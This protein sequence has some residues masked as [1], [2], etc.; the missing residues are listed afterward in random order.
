MYK[1]LILLLLASYVL[2]EREITESC[3]AASSMS[4]GE[5]NKVS[6]RS[7]PSTPT[8]DFADDL[9]SRV[10]AA[11]DFGHS[12]H[13]IPSGVYYPSSDAQISEIVKQTIRDNGQ[14]SVRG[15]GHGTNGQMQCCGCT[16]IDMR[17]MNQI[18]NVTE[19]SIYIEAGASLGVAYSALSALGKALV[20]QT[21]WPRLSVGGVMSGSGG[22]GPGLFRH[23]YLSDSILE[24][25][26]VD[27]KGEI[28]V[29]SPT[30][31]GELFNAVVSSLGQFG[32]MTAVKFRAVDIPG[33]KIR[34]YHIYQTLDRVFET[35]EKVLD[36][37]SNG[38]AP[39]HQFKYFPVL[40]QAGSG[41]P[42]G[43]PADFTVSDFGVTD[44]FV[45]ILEWG[46]Y[47][48]I[49]DEPNDQ[50]Q[51]DYF[52]FINGS[53]IS[54]DSDYEQWIYRLDFLFDVLLPS[55]AFN[56]G[57][58]N[59]H[60]WFGVV[61]P[62]E[63]AKQYVENFFENTPANDIPF[64]TVVVMNALI[65]PVVKP[66]FK[67]LPDSEV[68]RLVYLG[69][70][71][72]VDIGTTLD[73]Y[74]ENARLTQVNSVHRHSAE[75]VGGVPYLTSMIPSSKSEW[76][77]LPGFDAQLYKKA[78]AAYDPHYILQP[79]ISSMISG[80]LEPCERNGSGNFQG[81]V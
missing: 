8:A 44:D 34:N 4:P 30:Q 42:S 13:N 70:L 45:Y 19:D 1:Y 40:N 11:D 55:P 81:T 23:G 62:F 16:V 20:T 5:Q 46:V 59:P 80:R 31:N 43:Y 35:M 10:A 72:Q 57:W 25:T 60:P 38:G 66:A 18:R 76:I 77:A 58:G 75:A 29:V 26:V 50:T 28:H 73:V 53:Q 9:E 27:G 32:I 52:N 33:E 78:K 64:G 17:N 74:V 3:N 47:Y 51:F 65:E 41:V 24:L 2:C 21:D 6:E 61:L 37:E 67:P 68:D 14:I 22:S 12:V 36:D 15:F 39:F 48:D 49:G 63:E 7:F 69:V 54:S 71:R 79:G 56:Y